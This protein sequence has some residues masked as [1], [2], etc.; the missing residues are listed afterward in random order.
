MLRG[1]RKNLVTVLAGLLIATSVGTLPGAADIA[2]AAQ[3]EAVKTEQ[4]E[5]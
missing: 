4:S 5:V 3:K 2:Y 1:F